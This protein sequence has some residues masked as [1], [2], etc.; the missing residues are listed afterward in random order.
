MSQTIVAI[1]VGGTGA[2]NASDARFNLGAVNV[3][4]DVITGT[5]NVAATLI[6]QNVLP[7]ANV[8]YDLGSNTARYKDLWLSNSTIYLGEATISANGNT[9][10]VPAIETSSGVNVESQLGVVYNQANAAYDQANTARSDSNTT[11]ANINVAFSNT[12]SAF[13]T[14]NTTFGTLNTSA[15]TQNTWINNLNTATGTINSH[16]GTI[17][18]TFGTVNTAVTNAHNQANA[19]YA[20]A[21]LKLNIAGGT[22]NGSLNVSGN[23][24]ITGNTKYVNVDTYIV[25]DPLIYLAANNETSDIVDIG[26]MG[27]HNTS[28]VYSHSGL[29]RDAG[30]G[31]WYLF[32]GLADEGHENNVVDFANTTL[33]TLRANINANSILLT[34]NSVATQANLTLA[35]NQANTARNQANTAYGQANLAYTQAN[36]AFAAAN[37][38]VLKAGDTMT[39]ELNVANNLVVTGNVGIG[40]ASPNAR[41][42]V[43]GQVIFGN[44]GN[45]ANIA[46]LIS[47]TPPQ[48]VAG[49]SIPAITWS[50][51]A[52]IEA[53]FARDGD[54]GI[55]ILAGDTSSSLINFS[56]TNDENVGQI[57]YDH[58]TDYM[59]FRVNAGER[60][61]IDSSGNVGIGTT[62]LT[63][64]LTVNGTSRFLNNLVVSRNN[65]STVLN[66]INESSSVSR[67]PQL[68]IDNYDSSNGMGVVELKRARGSLASPASVQAG[69]LLG[70]FNTWGSNGAAFISATRIQGHADSTFSSTVNAYITFLTTSANTQAE[71][72]RITSSGN[73][74]IGTTSP[75]Q[76]LDVNG[77][78][79]IRTRLTVGNSSE[80]DTNGN[81][82]VYGNGKNML[83]VQTN[84]NSLD[85]GLAFRNSAG[86]YV[87]HISAT[88]AGSNLVDMVFGVSD[89]TETFVD[90]VDE[91]M[92]I[93]ASGN[94]GIGTTSPGVRLHAFT[95]DVSTQ[96]IFE[97]G[98]GASV[99]RFKDSGFSLSFP[100]QF[101]SN[102]DD[103]FWQIN[104]SEAMRLNSSA[105][106]GIGANPQYRLHIADDAFPCLGVYRALD[107]NS[108]GAA[109]QRIEIGALDGTTSKPGAGITGVLNSATDGYLIFETRSSSALG[110]R[111]RIASSGDV[112]IG[113]TNPTNKLE[114]DGG[115]A[116]VALRIS[117][118]NSGSDV[119]SL[120]LSNSSKS[121]F[122]DG[123]KISHGGGYTTFKDLSS[124]TIMAFDV[125][126]TRVGIGTGSPGVPFHVVA[127]NGGAIINSSTGTNRVWLRVNNT[128]GDFYLGREDSTGGFFGTGA[129]YASVLWS[130]GA[131]PLI[132][133]SNGAE[134]M[135]ITSGGTVLI[136]TTASYT[137]YGLVQIR[138]DN[139]GVAIQDST[140]GSYRAIYNQSGLLYFWNGSN[141]G[142]LSSAGAWIDASDA[143]LKEN[144]T[145]IKH[146]LDSV[147][148]SQPRSYKMKDGNAEYVGF[149]AQEMLDVIPE[150][151]SGKPEKQYGISYG[152]LVA[153][154]FRAIQE[155]Q[156]IIESL[157][158]RIEE[159][160]NK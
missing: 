145:P 116:A 152:S 62:N 86:A 115:S 21:N 113:T 157:K 70:G 125:T 34:G 91:R 45:S 160:E 52:T 103:L 29:V 40:A 59:R 8:T 105:D 154:A 30:D 26:F 73:V 32:T 87:G 11:F 19:A 38:R 150:C 124:N 48:L 18:T 22:I 106:L 54:M 68:S 58:A 131:H 128:G 129:A 141:E 127:P 23:L 90:D 2:N 16:L 89:A 156:A 61:R 5:L 39:G 13:T 71:R 50:P 93:T 120:I 78:G 111:V 46:N 118:T 109:G 36:S 1:D 96:A 79:L 31:T 24:T 158:L 117:T 151:V 25:T 134:R 3:A 47:G 76:L 92:R 15:G 57:E 82:I 10:I 72:V 12:N 130:Q 148:K 149:I 143:R 7:D 138:G 122:N 139:K 94:V 55:D 4:G 41:L 144:V 107:I 28:G 153:V 100:P 14:T 136:G 37:N 110:E 77:V 101:G 65:A 6:T 135:R 102:G 83:I 75:T 159:L 104:G 17:N 84:D 49:W 80:Y 85:R 43:R 64:L 63:S 44:A 67:F 99:I 98:T 9:I 60:L 137:D 88:N 56:D 133:A 20:E 119:A 140:D 132:L 121:A 69:D 142:Y 112:G 81:L 147:M 74:G 53:V 146:G 35:H 97:S 123:I 42:D 155:Q 51:A 108:V 33:A 66:I 114:V 27:G 126:N 95:S